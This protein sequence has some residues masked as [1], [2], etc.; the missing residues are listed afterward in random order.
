MKM[1]DL[2]AGFA[3]QLTTA[4]DM[5]IAAKL[6]PL[7]NEIRNVAL[8]GLGGSA[9][10]GE[11]TKNAL[12]MNVP[13]Q[14]HRNYDAPNYVSP[15][16]LVIASS[17]SGNTE[18][19]LQAVTGCSEKGATIVCVTS[20]GELAK[21]AKKYDYDVI[22]LPAGYPPRTAAGFSFVQQLFILKHF[23]LIGEFAPDIHEAIHLLESFDDHDLAKAIATNAAE[24]AV[25]LYSS[26][27]LE[28]VA[29]RFRQQINENAKQLCWNHYL[30]EMNHNELVGWEKPDF[31]LPKTFVILLR[32]TYDHPRVALRFDINKEIIEPKSGK[33]M[34]VWAKG[35]SKIAQLMYLLHLADWVSVYL[36]ELNSVDPTPVQVIDYLK[37]ALSMR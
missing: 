21:F 14:I 37:N 8:L 20:G 29:I 23:G 3:K 24:K 16:S 13:F 35:T 9:F 2:I 34:E 30:P 7:R 31:L 28:S 15:N 26:D 12:K 25:V 1:K 11:L 19:T 4:M 32:W 6:S 33:L 18:E 5:G 27:A 36:A 17:Y 10:G 22:L